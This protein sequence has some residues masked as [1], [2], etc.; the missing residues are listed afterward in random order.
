MTVQIYDV[1]LDSGFRCNC[2]SAMA[3]DFGHFSPERWMRFDHLHDVSDWGRV[4]YRPKF[5]VLNQYPN[6]RGYASVRFRGEDYNRPVHMM[7][8]PTFY[9]RQWYSPNAVRSY[10]MIDH[11]NHNRMDPSL[12]NLRYSNNA[13]NQMNRRNVKGYYAQKKKNG[14]LT[15]RYCVDIRINKKST[16]LGTFG[17]KEEAGE[18][19]H[20]A[21]K[22]A[23][24]VLEY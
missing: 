4:G 24:T 19:Y 20:E 8:L 3:K 16:R 5:R 11:K 6:G 13:L 12:E 1:A 14:T 17:S 15:G 21:L 2:I 10:D 7:V 23:F 18:R 9:P 22:D